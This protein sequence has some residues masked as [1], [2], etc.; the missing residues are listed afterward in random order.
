MTVVKLD[1]PY[2]SVV[3]HVLDDDVFS[4]I[5]LVARDTNPLASI[6]FGECLCSDHKLRDHHPLS[7]SSQ[8]LK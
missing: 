2:V 5:R 8:Q 3:S 1:P 4:S 6:R 7:E